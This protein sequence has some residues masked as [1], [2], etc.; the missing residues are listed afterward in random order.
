MPRQA[1]IDFPGSLQYLMVRG[2]ERKRIFRNDLDRKAFLDRLGSL[3]V[4][5]NTPCLAWVLMP[6]HVHLVL[7]T[8]CIPLAG[9]M[10]R[11]QG[12]RRGR[13]DIVEK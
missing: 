10:R 12:G 9:L 4:E 2:I 8:G 11:G 7:R 3:V 13:G 5:T 6:N 1:R